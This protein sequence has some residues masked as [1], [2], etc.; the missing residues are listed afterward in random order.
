MNTLRIAENVVE[1]A[2]TC[3]V[4]LQEHFENS[5]GRDTIVRNYIYP[6]AIEAEAIL[7]SDEYDFEEMTYY[8]F[9]DIFTDKKLNEVL[10]R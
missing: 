4:P 8:E 3:L 7:S 9:M 10:C 5:F 2:D 1:I 6:W